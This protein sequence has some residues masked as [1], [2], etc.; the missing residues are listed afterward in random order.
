[1]VKELSA[2]TLQPKQ[3]AEPVRVDQPRNRSDQRSA[4]EILVEVEKSWKGN[5]RRMAATRIMLTF[6]GRVEGA[7]WQ[8]K[9]DHAEQRYPSLPWIDRLG[10]PF[11]ECSEYQRANY[12][13]QGLN[14]LISLDVL[15]LSY[16]DLYALRVDY[17]VIRLCR[18]SAL[19]QHAEA[20]KESGVPPVTVAVGLRMLSRIL[21]HT[22]LPENEVSITHLQEAVA[23]AP[24]RRQASGGAAAWELLRAVGAIDRASPSFRELTLSD[25]RLN[26]KQ[27]V[28]YYDIQPAGIAELFVRYLL[29]RAPNLDYISLKGLAYDLLRNFWVDVRENHPYQET[30]HLEFEQGRS[31][32]ARFRAKPIADKHR[33]IFA[34]RSL[35]NDV[36]GWA[37]TD[38][39][40]ARWAVP[41]FL[42]K[43]DA[44]GAMKQKRLVQA[45]NHQR[46]RVLAPEMPR[47]M[48]SLEQ[49]RVAQQQLLEI[50]RSTERG[51]AFQFGGRRYRRPLLKESR[52][53]ETV[54]VVDLD[55]GK[56]INQ[57]YIEEIAFLG[58]AGANI[59]HET[60]IRLE[61]LLELTSTAITTYTSARTGERLLLLQI[62][63]SKS[64][65]ERLLV[66][67]PEL[68][69][70]LALLKQRIRG[71]H[72]HVPLATRYDPYE[73]VLSEPLPFLFQAQRGVD[74]RV[75]A[76]GTLSNALK[77]A[78]LI[79]GIK[80]DEK[81]LPAITAH[82][83][84]RIFATNALSAGLPVHI[85]A[86]LLG[87]DD[88]RTTQG[89]T[90]VYDE[91]VHR[92]F[93]S[94]LDRRRKLRPVEDYREPS[95]EEL[96]EFH[97]HFGLRKLELG[98]CARAYN[99]PCIHE[100]ACIR[101]PM[102][103]P[104]PDQRD[105]L[106][107]ILEGLK[108]RLKTAKRHGWLGEVE[109]IQISLDGAQEK[110]EG[111]SKRIRLSMP[112]FPPKINVSDLPDSEV[113][114]PEP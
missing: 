70:V 47:L 28:E 44:S 102:L 57:N 103:R 99:T 112:T 30:L 3:I 34:I 93:R 94:F 16:R 25:R 90:A 58:W 89:Y 108:E 73:R 33:T 62:V 36:A 64:D 88:I 98:T 113:D 104:D 1:M 92:H 60:G 12:P 43:S 41:C 75:I 55:T 111:M 6:L 51:V 77:R 49:D 85:L 63:P 97:A 24:T 109:G 86:R 87:H 15:R 21:A 19:D 95:P 96:E 54:W 29:Y 78:L 71:D 13:Q 9:W 38:P 20:L 91:D 10:D 101:C 76:P 106:E 22:G 72:E 23:A 35:Y 26:V 110:L 31:W 45:R 66:V 67:S 48:E 53:P 82:D 81:K 8:E 84:R 37:T 14:S 42:K 18:G 100:H 27:I 79:A 69:H 83:F 68:A 65:T 32:L 17:S 59:L 46:I 7:T 52:N 4:A 56:R 74:R 105:R 50:A 40:W 80:N 39:Y 2:G 5:K 107:E 114:S 61:E 11:S